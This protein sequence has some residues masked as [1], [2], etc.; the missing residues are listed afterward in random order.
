MRRR[1]RHRLQ[2]RQVSFKNFLLRVLKATHPTVGVSVAAAQIVDD[3]L[4]QLLRDIA[5][6][7]VLLCEMQMRP[8]RTVSSREI[9]SAVRLCM[10]GRLCMHAVCDGTKAVTKFLMGGGTG[11]LIAV[12]RVKAD[13]R[14][15]VDGLRVGAGAPVYLAW[16]ARV[17]RGCLSAVAPS[18]CSKTTRSLVS[19]HGIFLSPCPTTK[20]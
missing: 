5:V 6:E 3:M 18:L 4:T 13:L 9:Q 12:S 11:L 15:R 1:L 14:Q 10:P 2:R 19:R 20:S 16:C 8:R 7:A 17:S